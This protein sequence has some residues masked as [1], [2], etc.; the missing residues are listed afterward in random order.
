M[1]PA[2]LPAS[3]VR[4][5]HRRGS[6]PPAGQHSGGGSRPDA[7]TPDLAA[8]VRLAAG[9]SGAGRDGGPAGPAGRSRRPSARPLL[10]GAS[11]FLGAFLL[12][13]LIETTDG[14]VDCLVR[15]EDEQRAAHRLRANLERYGLWNPGTRP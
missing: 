8:E 12:R 1:R 7:A 10:T 4:D 14:P 5:T 2:P 6:R 15:A 13:D 3:S 9:I 11:G